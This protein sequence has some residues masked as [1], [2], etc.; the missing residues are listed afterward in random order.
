MSKIGHTPSLARGQP[1][2]YNLLLGI[3]RGVRGTVAG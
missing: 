2:G 3:A 1:N